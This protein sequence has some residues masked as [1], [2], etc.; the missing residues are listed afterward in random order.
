MWAFL[1][2]LP[3]ELWNSLTATIK[4]IATFI[5]G[6]EW[7]KLIQQAAENKRLNEQLQSV[8]KIEREIRES[9]RS[10]DVPERLRKYYIDQKPKS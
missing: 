6:V 2:S 5:A 10:G 9:A 1:K 4:T 8:I 3:L 7:Q